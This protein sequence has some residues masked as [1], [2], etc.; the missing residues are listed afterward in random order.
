[1]AIIQD[2]FRF[3]EDGTESGSTA[4]AAQ[5]TS[6]NRTVAADSNLL[7]RLR[8]ESTTAMASVPPSV[9]RL[10]YS[11][12]SGTWT[13]LT[14][15]SS[16]VKAFNSSNLTDGGST[17]ERLTSGVTTW[18]AGLI[19]EDGE[20]GDVPG[21][22]GKNVTSGEYTEFLYT[23]TVLDADVA[24]FDTLDFRV[25]RDGSVIDTYTVTPRITVV[26]SG[27]GGSGSGSL[28]LLGVG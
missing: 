22:L 16:D 8:I 27:G 2:A 28:L 18:T 10:Q 21:E 23:L 1:M 12:N 6:I 14:T 3:Y 26:K 7:L 20:V 13:N 25:L 17:T 4:I 24:N 15:S 5:D 9:W 19:A 11:K